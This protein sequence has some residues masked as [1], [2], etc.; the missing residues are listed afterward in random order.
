MRQIR[1]NKQIDEFEYGQQT[2]HTKKLNELSFYNNAAAE[3]KK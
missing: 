3:G 2:K 1:V